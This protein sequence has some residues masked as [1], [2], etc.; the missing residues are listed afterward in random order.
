M[1]EDLEPKIY[2]NQPLTNG[3]VEKNQFIL[4]LGEIAVETRIREVLG[5]N[6]KT[7]NDLKDR[8]IL[9]RTGTYGEFLTKVFTHYKTQNEVGL[10]KV[11]A[12]K[13]EFA[14]KRTSRNADTESG[15]PRVVEAEKIQKIRLDAAR[16]RQIHLQNLQ[17]RN[18]LISKVEVFDIIAPLVGTIVNVLRSAAD[19][20]PKLQVPVDKC[21]SSLY[22][23]AQMLLRQAG[24][25]GD[26]YVEEMMNKPVDIDEL[27][28]NADLEIS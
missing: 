17:V 24:V 4:S 10:A 9:P 23:V 16:E 3:K 11:E 15:L 22:S 27:L 25:D 13:E 2:I 7:W 5:V 28:D 1:M 6:P 8:G 14:S 21:F 26:S 12:R 20:D 18:E 19:D